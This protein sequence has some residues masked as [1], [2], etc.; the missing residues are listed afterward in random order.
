M[1]F[2]FTPLQ[3]WPFGDLPAHWFN[4]IVADPPWR[5]EAYSEAGEEKSPQAH[6]A[7]MPPEDVA[8]T[9]PIGELAD[10]NC[11]LLCWGTWPLIDRQIECVK[12]WGFEYKSM[13]VWSKVFQSGKRAWGPGYRVRSLCEPVI[14]ATR[15]EPRHDPLPG[16]FDGVRREHSRKPEEFYEIIDRQCPGLRRRADLFTRQT[17]DGWRGWGNEATKFD[18]AAS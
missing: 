7:C 15:G 12:L 10:I 3:P 4:L 16:L 9:F 5:F 14:V 17:R 11:L 8:L 1:H 2:I 6:Y 18:E 13:L